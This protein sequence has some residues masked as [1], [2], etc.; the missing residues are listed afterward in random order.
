MR[1]RRA[2]SIAIFIVAA[3]VPLGARAAQPGDKAAAQALFDEGLALMNEGR[4]PEACPKLEESARIDPAMGTRFRLAECHEAIG[5]TASAWAG[6]VEV[7]DLA[8]AAGQ[9]AREN[10]ARS[11]AEAL[12]PR[13]AHLVIVA[14]ATPALEVRRDGSIIGEAQWGQKIPIDPGITRI[15]AT[16]P[17][18][19]GWSS[20]VEIAPGPVTVEVRVPVLAPSP[21][22]NAE[23]AKAVETGGPR[24]TLGIVGVGVGAVTLATSGVLG[25]VALGRYRDAER[26][27]CAGD[28]CNA[29]GKDDTDAARSLGHV[30]TWVGVA[31]AALAAGGALLWLSAPTSSTRVAIGPATLLFEGR[32]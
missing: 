4:H 29:Q 32:F 21:S 2:L 15:T 31:G 24:R 12:R 13:L 10:V 3:G 6:F 11:R 8:K 7:A 14:E 9:D 18:R 5:R 22:A 16:A 25:L 1:T 26:D 27:H 20:D 28:T 23:P 17:G 19:K 30:A